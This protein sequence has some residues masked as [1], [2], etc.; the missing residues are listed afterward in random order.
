MQKRAA[1]L[2]P[3]Q[4]LR[5]R[6]APRASTPRPAAASI[7]H[8]RLRASILRGA[9]PPGSVVSDHLLAREL[10][11]SRTPVREAFL[12]LQ[13][14]GLVEVVPQV[15]T[16][17]SRLDRHAVR[18]ALFA[19]EQLECGALAERID[20]IGPAELAE[21]E[22]CARRQRSAL[23]AAD[24][25]AVMAEDDTFHFLLLR[26][27]GRSGVW[28]VVRDV[29]DLMRRVRALALPNLS[30]GRAA[31]AQHDRIVDALRRG[32]NTEAV[33]LLRT[34]IRDN[35]AMTGRLA[36]RFPHYFTEDEG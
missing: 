34:H 2:V 22:A 27:A 24:Y 14:E 19:R 31:I 1:G 20:P 5:A 21:I 3:T 17:V 7:A 9:L 16:F 29:R 28:P 32:G 18:D 35:A 23:Q 30:A 33:A 36:A 12:R 15:G 11:V 25:E 26:L 13:L 8:E 6:P 10:G 4:S